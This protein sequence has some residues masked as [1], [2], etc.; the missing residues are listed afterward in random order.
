MRMSRMLLIMLSL[1]FFSCSASAT[2]FL[3][4]DPN[5]ESDL[6]GYRVYYGEISGKYTQSID[7]GNVTS[8]PFDVQDP[9][10]EYYIVVSAYDTS[11]NESIMSNEVLYVNAPKQVKNLIITDMVPTTFKKQDKE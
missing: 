6:A 1:L 9:D 11:G 2:S 4:W 7:V 5:S 10:Q 8:Y 3:S